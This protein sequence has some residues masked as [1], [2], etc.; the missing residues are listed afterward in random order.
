MEIRN[1]RHGNLRGTEEFYFV[2]VGF[3][4]SVVNIQDALDIWIWSSVE[5]SG[6]EILSL[7]IINL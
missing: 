7:A 2:L 4:L 5:K 1:L 3:K 6:L